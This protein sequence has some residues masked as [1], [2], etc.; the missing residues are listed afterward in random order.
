MF[1]I[2]IDISSHNEIIG[3]T[4]MFLV[5]GEKVMQNYFI[6]NPLTPID[7]YRGRSA[8]LTSKVAFYIFIEQI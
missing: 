5:F 3:L 4:K 7:P 6:L 2:L 1:I 8:P